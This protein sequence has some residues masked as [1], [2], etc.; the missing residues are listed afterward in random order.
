MPLPP[1]PAFVG[2]WRS[3]FASGVDR[4]SAAEELT[5]P[6]HVEAGSLTVR[7][8][9]LATVVRAAFGED[10][11][12]AL[13]ELLEAQSARRAEDG[14]SSPTTLGPKTR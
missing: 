13:P 4:P 14:R 12:A 5:T 9:G 7:V 3:T 6:T 1:T 8:L 11:H 2:L 10:A